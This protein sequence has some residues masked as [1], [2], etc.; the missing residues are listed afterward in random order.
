MLAL[1]V[2][3]RGQTVS[4]PGPRTVRW[5]DNFSIPVPL[6]TM[7]SL[8]KIEGSGRVGRNAKKRYGMEIDG[9]EDS[10][11]DKIIETQRSKTRTV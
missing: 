6:P 9:M 2:I 8:Q 11:G 10:H 4:N 1:A 5:G 7:L 3:F